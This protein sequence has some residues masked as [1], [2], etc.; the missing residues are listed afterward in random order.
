M[1]GCVGDNRECH[2]WLR[3]GP[4]RASVWL[5]RREML[6]GQL[7]SALGVPQGHATGGVR[8]LEVSW[9][10]TLELSKLRM[11]QRH[12]DRPGGVPVGR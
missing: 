5:G 10:C 8:L 4:K 1:T 3:G 6:R 2:P 9:V 11:L 7:G 12:E